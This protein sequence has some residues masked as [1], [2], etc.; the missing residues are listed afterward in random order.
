MS[1]T[2]D[3]KTADLCDEHSGSASF[4]VAEP[5][6]FDYG[7]R[8]SFS[9]PISTVRAPEDNTLVRKALEEP[10]QG[11]V[12]VV[13]GGGSRRCAL[14]GDLLAALAQKNGWAGVVVNGCIRDAEEVGR[15]PIGVKALGTHPLKSGKRNEGQRDVEVRFAGV[16]FKP[17]HYLYADADGIVTAEKSLR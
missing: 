5:G 13:D 3:L 11:R 2:T 10:G 17:G 1:D 16:T 14:V 6:F 8:R 4:Q 12:L 15:T 7:G 9:G